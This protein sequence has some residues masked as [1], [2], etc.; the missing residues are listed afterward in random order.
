MWNLPCSDP[1][2]RYH[3]AG[4]LFLLDLSGDRPWLQYN[5]ITTIL[6]GEQLM[7]AGQNRIAPTPTLIKRR[8]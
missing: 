2:N 3:G 4:V 5:Q 1:Q 7:A 8:N 6:I